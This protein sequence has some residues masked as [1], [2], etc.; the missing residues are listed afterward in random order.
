MIAADFEKKKQSDFAND[1][2]NFSD[3]FFDIN[4]F[5]RIS[6]TS[7]LPNSAKPAKKQPQ[8]VPNQS[9]LSLKALKNICW[10]SQSSKN[11]QPLTSLLNIKKQT[12]QNKK[13][14][15][16]SFNAKNQKGN[17]KI[18]E[19]FKLD[20]FLNSKKSHQITKSDVSGLLNNHLIE[21]EYE[22]LTIPNTDFIKYTLTDK[23][24]SLSSRTHAS[25]SNKAHASPKLN[26]TSCCN[27]DILH[28]VSPKSTQNKV[29]EQNKQNATEQFVQTQRKLTSKHK[30]QVSSTV[31]P[32]QNLFEQ[33]E[34][35]TLKQSQFKANHKG[36]ITNN[37]QQNKNIT[38]F[39]DHL[40]TKQGS[41]P[42]L[43]IKDLLDQE[44]NKDFQL[45]KN[46]NQSIKVQNEIENRK[47]ST[48]NIGI[49]LEKK[50]EELKQKYMK[51][52]FEPD[53]V[54]NGRRPSKEKQ[55]KLS[56]TNPL[57]TEVDKSS[58]V[59]RSQAFILNQFQ[60][61][62]QQNTLNKKPRIWSAQPQLNDGNNK[63][64]SKITS[65]SFFGN[66]KN[67]SLN[68]NQSKTQ[69][70]EDEDIQVQ[71]NQHLTAQKIEESKEGK[72]KNIYS[73]SNPYYNQTYIKQHLKQ[74]QQ[75]S[76]SYF[77]QMIHPELQSFTSLQR[78]PTK[79][80]IN[81]IINTPN[82]QSN[83]KTPNKKVS[84]NS[85]TKIHQQVNN[86]K[87][88]STNKS[89]EILLQRSRTFDEEKYQKEIESNLT[90]YKYSSNYYRPQTARLQSQNKSQRKKDDNQ[91]RKSYDSLKSWENLDIDDNS[92]IL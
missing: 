7:L 33:S 55:Q 48:H 76:T 45:T 17:F 70:R 8:K 18:H 2:Q 71:Q 34:N 30:P 19:M 31:N 37:A 60:K 43:L 75:T 41:N 88:I 24:G 61:K 42:S 23:C 46:Y 22:T 35:N 47:Q 51:K 87:V 77:K 56:I 81:Q 12:K 40:K 67:Q 89:E 11:T 1:L 59:D 65:A 83:T 79:E 27:N 69:L 80:A 14:S 13:T 21:N 15:A 53:G 63:Q 36:N 73:N 44:K 3:V 66:V 57:F 74:S 39:Q 28:N 54:L 5:Q 90:I 26:F 25:Y 50:E 4:P 92:G 84:L 52:I 62:Q 64:E 85:N 32:T 20:D 91:L 82:N 68:I 38:K 49:E 6:L 58:L 9:Q 78:K 10:Q 86:K 29:N 72:V 16:T